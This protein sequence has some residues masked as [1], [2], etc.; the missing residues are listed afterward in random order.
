MESYILSILSIYDSLVRPK[1]WALSYGP[2]SL[3]QSSAIDEDGLVGC[4]LATEGV[5]SS[6]TRF[7]GGWGAAAEC[8]KVDHNSGDL[9][10]SFLYF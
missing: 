8:V 1:L 3:S 10:F 7:S 2:N 5:L 9:L 4:L 6:R